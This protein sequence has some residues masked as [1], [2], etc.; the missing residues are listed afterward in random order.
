MT[1]WPA[2][3]E[4]T[5]LTDPNLASSLAQTTDPRHVQ[6]ADERRQRLSKRRAWL[7]LG[8]DSEWPGI[9]GEHWSAAKERQR[10]WRKN[11]EKA[12]GGA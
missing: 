7:G 4:E 9:A 2:V 5:P 1:C 11:R 8:P 3:A 6:I 12:H 10:A